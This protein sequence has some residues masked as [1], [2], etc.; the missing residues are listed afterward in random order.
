ML[1]LKKLYIRLVLKLLPESFVETQVSLTEPGEN[2]AWVYDYFSLR[3][4]LLEA[5]FSSVMKMSASTSNLI[6]FPYRT[7]DTDGFEV[8]IKGKETM[9]IEAFR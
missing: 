6:D 7:L 1:F 2:H 3:N 9:F 5:G 4:N 8:P